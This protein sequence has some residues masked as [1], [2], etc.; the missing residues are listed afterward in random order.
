MFAACYSHSPLSVLAELSI[1]P[2]AGRAW[3]FTSGSSFLFAVTWSRAGTGL[4]WPLPPTHSQYTSILAASGQIIFP[5]YWDKIGGFIRLQGGEQGVPGLTRTLHNTW[6]TTQPK[7]SSQCLPRLLFVFSVAPS[8]PWSH[9][10]SVSIRYISDIIRWDVLL[11]EAGSA[12]ASGQDTC[13]GLSLVIGALW[14]TL[15]G[16]CITMKGSDWSVAD[17][18]SP[19]LVCDNYWED[20]S[21]T[22]YPWA[23]AKFIIIPFHIWNFHRILSS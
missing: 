5:Q 12:G 13:H 8:P 1:S 7:Y 11:S 10:F 17:G 21:M 22:N 23:L 2:W 3:L 20:A 4:T 15:I 19:T 9:L 16:Q 14:R 6:Q 18:V